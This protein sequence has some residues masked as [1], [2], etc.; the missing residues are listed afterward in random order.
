MQVHVTLNQ[1]AIFTFVSVSFEV[2]NMVS[3]PGISVFSW[4]LLLAHCTF[5]DIILQFF[6]SIFRFQFGGLTLSH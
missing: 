5:D 4:Y 1:S 3:S 6:K 2:T